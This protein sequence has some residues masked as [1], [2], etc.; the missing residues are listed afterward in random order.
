[1]GVLSYIGGDLLDGE[2][3]LRLH[4]P[5]IR[6]FLTEGV[7]VHSDDGDRVC[8]N[9]VNIAHDGVVA[10]VTKSLTSSWGWCVCL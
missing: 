8:S 7:E 9:F 5:K 4:K 3:Q 1:M 6:F 2:N 10:E